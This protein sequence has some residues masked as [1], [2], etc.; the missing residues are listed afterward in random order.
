[1]TIDKI[2]RAGLEPALLLEPLSIID[3]SVS[4]GT[5]DLDLNASFPYRILQVDCITA[6]GTCTIA[7][8]INGV[9]VAFD[10]TAEGTETAITVSSTAKSRVVDSL[11]DVPHSGRLQ[12][13]VSSNSSGVNLAIKVHI[14]RI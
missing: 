3:K 9:A 13:V 8:N 14:Q 5:F 4:D 1:M 2:Y 6:S 12:L 10:D 11:G 7:F